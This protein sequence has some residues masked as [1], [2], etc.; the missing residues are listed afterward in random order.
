VDQDKRHD[1]P[2][3]PL[4]DRLKDLV[5]RAIALPASE[6]RNFIASESA[7]DARLAI[8]AMDLVAAHEAA[9][10]FLG[11]PT[12]DP[13][14]PAGRS[15]ADL[16]QVARLEQPGTRIGAY[17]L[18]ELI[19]E[20]GFGSVFMAEQS[21]PISRRVALK[22]V[23]PGMDSRMVAA[24]FEAERQALA[25][26][27]H[28]HIA[29]MFDGG[30]TDPSLGS[31]PYFV[32]EYVKGDPMTTFADAHKLSLR[33]RLDLFTQVCQAV[34]HAHT[35]GVI[36]RDLKP[37]N[38]LV[39]MTDG[40]PFAKVIDFGIAKATG[41]KLTERTLFTE[42]RQLIGTPEYMSPEQ[43]D[44]SPDLDTRTDVYALG[45]L[46]YELLTG[47]TPFD[48][49]RLR[50]AAFAEMQRIIKEEDPPAP[51]VRLSRDLKMLADAAGA[52]RAEPATL[53]P[54]VKGEL[55][56]IVMKCLDKDRARRYESANQLAE[57]VRRHLAGDAVVA[58]PPSLG[59]R[60]RK[61]VKRRKAA[62]ATA[63][64]I[65]ICVI[66]AAVMTAIAQSRLESRERSLR[67]VVEL[68]GA[69][70]GDLSDRGRVTQNFAAADPAER[71][72]HVPGSRFT[73]F[74]RE[75][76]RQDPGIWWG[77]AADGSRT[78]GT[79]YYEGELGSIDP[80]NLRTGLR[81]LGQKALDSTLGLALLESKVETMK[82]DLEQQLQSNRLA[83]A[84][85][86]LATQS[87]PDTPYR[88]EESELKAVA[89]TFND[90]LGPGSRESIAASF[91]LLVAR[92]NAGSRSESIAE[93]EQLAMRASAAP[94]IGVHE[95]INLQ[96]TLASWQVD[97]F[98]LD[99][100]ART[101]ANVAATLTST[102][103]INIDSDTSIEL[104]PTRILGDTGYAWE[105][106]LVPR[107]LLSNRLFPE[108]LAYLQSLDAAS[109]KQKA[110]ERAI[111]Q[112]RDIVNVSPSSSAILL[113]R[114][115]R[116]SAFVPESTVPDRAIALG[117]LRSGRPAEA[118]E[119]IAECIRRDSAECDL[120]GV[121][122]LTTCDDLVCNLAI[123]VIC[124][125]KLGRKD[126]ACSGMMEVHTLMASPAFSYV[127]EPAFSAGRR[128]QWAVRSLVH[129]AEDLM[130][131]SGCQ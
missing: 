86:S 120:E 35:K 66:G 100:A 110:I 24:R 79:G 54:A 53:G 18:L 57:D 107:E 28:P 70:M 61:F 59:Y 34:Q 119:R 115:T 124:E 55:D 127:R 96:L 118:L 62:L 30:V 85:L 21:D 42:H 10:S 92:F 72:A 101:Y 71:F 99:G 22:I 8:D 41:A 89:A 44:G 67:E 112:C 88:L 25:L 105:S 117:L 48:A 73:K 81:Y 16:P 130:R 1:Q 69:L 32:M 46:L 11:S 131:K 45:V 52:R 49:K 80:K 50:S 82:K 12:S 6:R 74:C 106:S 63:S 104:H 125:A 75:F 126:E 17:K 114:A 7:G 5:F 43:A 121:S 129:E 111:E 78:F 40:R 109:L 87:F 91:L 116:L 4:S 103:P 102:G 33:A 36:H 26:M 19:G 51:S 77:T 56:W 27:E 90:L 108:M 31:R 97:D 84:R 122:T 37:S 94:E 23:K 65:T 98:D 20:G 128:S 39:N 14:S 38:V 60:V 68:L 95:S 29:R 2:E 76:D 123:R 113:R 83:G 9:G 15:T 47:S 13:A 58:A 64:T 3:S 93:L